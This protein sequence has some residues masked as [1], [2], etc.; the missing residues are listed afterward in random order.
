MM[1]QEKKTPASARKPVKRKAKDK[2]KR[3]LSAY[4]FF[5]KEEREKIVSV[6]LNEDPSSEEVQKSDLTPEEI[7]KLRKD[8]GKVNFEEMGKLIGS[9][10]RVISQDPER[11]QKYEELAEGDTARYKDEMEKYNKKQEEL[12]E[13]EKQRAAEMQ[14]AQMQQ[15]PMRNEMPGM[16]PAQMGYAAYPMDPNTYPHMRVMGGGY[17]PFYMPPPNDDQERNGY[18]LQGNYMPQHPRYPTAPEFYQHNMPPNHEYYAQQK[19]P[20]K[21]SPQNVN[22]L[23]QQAYKEYPQQSSSYQQS[24]KEHAHNQQTNKEDYPQQSY[25]E[26]NYPKQSNV[27]DNYPQ[28]SYKE[29]NYKQGY[30]DVK[31]DW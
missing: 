4:N 22:E 9:R 17:G 21:S 6:V 15:Y 19:Q 18:P 20:K 13:K 23:P 8:T 28:Q 30:G 29:E 27:E 11:K 16:F 25:K 1:Y 26:D 10:W 3:P 12:R 2:P 31:E 14:Y 24:F 7:S 5:F